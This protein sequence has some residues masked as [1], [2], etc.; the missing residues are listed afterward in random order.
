MT[1][2]ANSIETVKAADF[3][4][5]VSLI[6]PKLTTARQTARMPRFFEDAANCFLER[7]YVNIFVQV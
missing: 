7:T 5:A 1:L 4:F 6:L 3:R 2:V